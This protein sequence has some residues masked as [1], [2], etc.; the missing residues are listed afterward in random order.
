LGKKI[1]VVAVHP[2]DES[3]GCGGTLLRHKQNGD[4][5]HWLVITNIFENKG[6]SKEVVS[7]RQEE[8]K[9]VAA[10]YSFDSVHLLDFPTTQ[11]E[12][13]PKG[14]LISEISK[15]FN[16]VKPNAIYLPFWGDAHS[17]HGHVFDCAYACTKSFRYPFIEEVYAF[18]TVSETEFSAPLKN[19]S[20]TPNY[21]VNISEHLKLKLEICNIYESEMHAHPFPRSTRNLEALAT[22]R[23][24]QA[25]FEYAEA[26]MNLL[27]RK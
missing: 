9:S 26:F 11:I 20:F 4:S 21:F 16:E 22:Y 6:F 3:L 18:E 7:K 19:A 24:A 25:G 17:E 27:T 12:E 10:K 15:V 14:K 1:I 8:I 13:L 23:G 5:I 2:D